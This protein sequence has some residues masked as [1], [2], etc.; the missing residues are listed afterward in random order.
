ML[1][2]PQIQC[3]IYRLQTET[4]FPVRPLWVEECNYIAVAHTE[5]GTG[6]IEAVAVDIAVVAH[7]VAAVATV[8]IAVVAHIVPVADIVVVAVVAYVALV[9]VA[10][11]VHHSLHK[12]VHLGQ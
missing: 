4:F 3:I 7:T 5:V 10:L 12:N 8:D 6:V 11:L 1:Q 2:V 9:V